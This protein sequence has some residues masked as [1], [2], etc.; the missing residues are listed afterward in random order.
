MVVKRFFGSAACRRYNIKFPK[1]IHVENPYAFYVHCF[2]HQLQL[3]IVSIASC[4]SSFDDF[5]NYVGLISP[6]LV[7]LVRGRINYKHNI[8]KPL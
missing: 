8:A 2:A 1:Q 6:V 5:F 3:V 4:C 7:H